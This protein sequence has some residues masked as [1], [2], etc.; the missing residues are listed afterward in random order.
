M[1]LGFANPSVERNVV[2]SCL[3]ALSLLLFTPDFSFAC[4]GGPLEVSTQQGCSFYVPYTEKSRATEIIEKNRERCGF[5]EEDIAQIAELIKEDLNVSDMP[6]AEFEELQRNSSIDEKC[7]SI[8]K[9]KRQ[10]RWTGLSM[11]TG[12]WDKRFSAC[13]MPKC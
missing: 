12:S 13:L 7:I 2:R 3:L 9:F 5:S 11:S 4:R 10:G 8:N 1:F 6:E